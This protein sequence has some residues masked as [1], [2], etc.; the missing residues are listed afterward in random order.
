MG[1]RIHMLDNRDP[2]T[3]WVW[4]DEYE[5]EAGYVELNPAE[6]TGNMIENCYNEDVL[7][8]FDRFS[9]YLDEMGEDE[10]ESNEIDHIVG[11][12]NYLTAMIESS[13]ASG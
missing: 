7:F 12:R 9:V 3:T 5:S 4:I 6:I 8:L 1:H 2:G 11:F 13:K 10:I